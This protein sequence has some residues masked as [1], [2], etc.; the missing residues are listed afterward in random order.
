MHVKVAGKDAVADSE[1]GLRRGRQLRPHRGRSSRGAGGQ[2]EGGNRSVSRPATRAEVRRPAGGQR[3]GPLGGSGDTVTGKA[4]GFELVA[5]TH[6]IIVTPWPRIIQVRDPDATLYN[7]SLVELL[8]RA[9]R[10]VH[11]K[12]RDRI[13]V[14]ILDE[15]LKIGWT[16]SMEAANDG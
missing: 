13:T 7:T 16:V 15:A 1:G 6:T 2:G 12:G 14:D 11:I 8:I 3:A 5:G 9:A 4:F 10:L